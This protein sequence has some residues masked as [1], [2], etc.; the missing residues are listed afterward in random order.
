VEDPPPRRAEK[1]EPDENLDDR[2]PGLAHHC[3]CS[4]LGL[5][6]VWNLAKDDDQL[7]VMCSVC[8]V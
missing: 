6:V 7:V 3:G 8:N 4:L 5:L 1:Q 2:A